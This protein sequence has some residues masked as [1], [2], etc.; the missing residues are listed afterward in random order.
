MK[1][2]IPVD[3]TV[4]LEQVKEYSLETIDEDIVY[5][6]GYMDCLLGEH[7]QGSPDY[8]DI[9]GDIDDI[10]EAVDDFKRDLKRFLSSLKAFRECVSEK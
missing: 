10:E 5:T 4:L 1:S 7:E 8:E 6:L 3:I 2:S 9:R